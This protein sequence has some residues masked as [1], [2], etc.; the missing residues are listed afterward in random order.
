MKTDTKYSLYNLLNNDDFIRWAF[1]PTEELNEYWSQI[2]ESDPVY[3]DNILKIKNLLTSI[4]INEPDFS[5]ED[6]SLLWEKIE[7]RS[8]KAHKV[9]WM[10]WHRIA[11]IAVG[12]IFLVSGSYFFYNRYSS[13]KEI[14]YSLMADQMSIPEKEEKIKLVIEG[15]EVE[16]EEENV[17]LIYDENGEMYAN[18]KKIEGRNKSDNS[19]TF[20]QLIV[21]NGR[22]SSII[23]YDG[24]KIWINSGSKL[25]Y[26]ATFENNKREIFI[27]GEVYLEVAKNEKIP[28]IV[29]TEKFRINVLGTSFNVQAYK[30][31]SSHSVVLATGS[32][33]VQNNE[34]K[35]KA[36]IKPNQMYLYRTE[37]KSAEID[38]VEI[39]DYICWKY[40]FLHFQS[41]RLSTVL[42]KLQRY[43][44]FPL[45]YNETEMQ[46]IRVSG[47]LDLKENIKDVFESIALT[48]PISCDVNENNIKIIVK[49]K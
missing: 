36:L 22:S 1:H 9:K 32:L 20:N 8:I 35:T 3:K 11:S 19:S 25:I 21:P 10:T 44:N 45:E 6:R 28:F 18:S 38:N 41:E 24:T 16:L 40:G 31:E 12:I 4:H 33:E 49:P 46:N 7:S 17:E 2:M 14:D 48:A 39:F 42:R 23:L 37:Q 13:G 27:E 29:K 30:G 15:K 47:K 26:P 43:Y 34:L 5:Y